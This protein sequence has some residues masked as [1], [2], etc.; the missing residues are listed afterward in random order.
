MPVNLDK[1]HLWKLDVAASVDMYNAWFMDFAPVAFRQTRVK[2][3]VSVEEALQ[4]TRYLRDIEPA[5]LRRHP[6]ILPTLRMSTC[7]PIAVD[8]LIGLAGV[9]K[10]LVQCM[11]A[12]H[13]LPP[14]MSV[15]EADAQLAKI[16]AILRAGLRRSISPLMPSSCRA[17]APQDHCRFSLRRSP[18]AIS[19]TPTSAAKRRP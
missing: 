5:T 17:P 16:A 9:S 12:D 19:P 18:Q 10:S 14:R 15:A 8:R 1:P 6:E 3:T 11:E 4:A 7:P 2:V 13:R